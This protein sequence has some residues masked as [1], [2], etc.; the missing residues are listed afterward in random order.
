[1]P[2]RV[3]AGG[4]AMVMDMGMGMAHGAMTGR[5]AMGTDSVAMVMTGRRDRSTVAGMAGTN[6]S[7][8]ASC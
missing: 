3:M 6:P 5:M 8:S 1:M 2:I 4:V 7:H